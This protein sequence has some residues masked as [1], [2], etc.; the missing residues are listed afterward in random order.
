MSALRNLANQ[1][2]SESRQRLEPLAAC[3]L[4]NWP[5]GQCA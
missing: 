3:N 1:R 2:T 4:F 5:G